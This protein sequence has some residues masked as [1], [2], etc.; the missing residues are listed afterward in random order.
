M[1]FVSNKTIWKTETLLLPF[2]LLQIFHQLEYVHFHWSFFFQVR[3]Y[4]FPSPIDLNPREKGK[5]VD[6]TWSRLIKRHCSPE[7]FE[8]KAYWE[9]SSLFGGKKVLEAKNNSFYLLF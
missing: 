7:C 5:H 4:P 2:V 6:K 3:N 9:V 8:N 1:V